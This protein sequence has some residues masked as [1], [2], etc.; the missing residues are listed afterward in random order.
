[1]DLPSITAL[2]EIVRDFIDG[3]GRQQCRQ[4]WMT[5]PTFEHGPAFDALD[6]GIIVLDEQAPIVGWNDWIARVSRRPQADGARQE[7]ATTYFRTGA[8][9]A[10]AFGHRRFVSSRQLEH[11]D[12]FVE[13]LLPLRGEDGK[14]CCTTLSSGRCPRQVPDHCLLQINDVTVAVT[15]ERVLRE[16]QNA[17]YHAIVDTHR[18]PSSR[19]DSTGP[20]N[21]STAPPSTYSA[22]PRPSCWDARSIFSSTDNDALSRA[23][24]A[25]GE[26]GKGAD[27]SLQVIGRR[28]HGP[29][30]HFEVSSARWRAD[31]RVFITTIWRDVTEQMAAEAA[32]RESESH[33]RALAGG[34]AATGVD[35]R[36]RWGLRLFQSAM[37]DLHRRSGG[38]ASGI[39]LDQG[40]TSRIRTRGSVGC[41]EVITVKRSRI[42]CRRTTA[43][44]GRHAPLVQDAID[45]G[46]GSRR[47]DHAVVRNG[48]RHNRSHRS[49]GCT[50]Q[51]QRRAGGSRR[52]ANARARGRASAA[53]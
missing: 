13:Q 45:P 30:A 39:G 15:R 29:L 22:M 17:R 32:L 34:L 44:R 2:K 51:K 18:M 4:C 16:R 53:S 21:G 36:S 48:H 41:V 33:H 6:V 27:S 42:R 40:R 19:R 20:S 43:T 49:A 26:S 38:A 8:E 24:I 14:S 25:E 1:M 35:L 10:A 46:A 31:D 50:A 23:F 5:C 11:P 9:H 3:I 28:K 47:T 7:P 12:A 52:R 37:A